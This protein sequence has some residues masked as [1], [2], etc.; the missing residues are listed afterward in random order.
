MLALALSMV[1]CQLG[2]G[3]NGGNNDNNGNNGNNTG[4]TPPAAD[5]NGEDAPIGTEGL[6]YNSQTELRIVLADSA[7]PSELSGELIWAL[8][9][10]LGSRLSVKY[11]D[12]DEAAAH[13]IVIGESG[14]V[15]S[16][17]AYSR[18]EELMDNRGGT[19]F[20]GYVLYSDGSSL[21][22]AYTEELGTQHVEEIIAELAEWATKTSLVKEKGVVSS[23]VYNMYEIY[24]NEDMERRDAA[25]AAL[26]SK[27]GT[28]VVKALKELYSS[29]YTSD[30]I[31]W[32]ANLYEPR[33]CICDNYV[34]GVRVCLHPTD[35]DGNYLCK[36][37]GFYYS[38]SAR[39]TYSF[40]PDI[41]ST[42]QALVFLE[43]TGMLDGFGGNFG[44][45]I[46]GQLRADIVAFTKGLQNPDGYFYHPQWTIEQTQKNWSRVSRDL[47]WS[48]AI[49][50]KFGESPY[51]TTPTGSMTGTGRP[52][53]PA[54]Y[55]TG[56]LAENAASAVSLVTPTASALPAHLQSADAF[57]AYLSQFKMDVY[58]LGYYASNELAA[59]VNQLTAA[60]KQ[61][62]G[63]IKPIL[64][65]FLEE[66]HN[67][68]NGLWRSEVDYDGLNT[69]FKAVMVYSAFGMPFTYAD[70]AVESAI[71]VLSSDEVPGHVCG[72]Y[73]TWYDISG[74]ISNIRKFQGSEI[75]DALQAK[76]IEIAPAAIKNT[77]RYTKIFRKPDGSFSY[78]SDHCS[79]TSQGMTVAL[80]C[81]EGDVNASLICTGGMMDHMGMALGVEL[82]PIFG[83]RQLAEFL[84]IIADNGYSIKDTLPPDVILEFDDESIGIESTTVS[85]A[86]SSG[87]SCAIE[88]DP[89]DEKNK[90]LHFV[91]LAKSGAWDA[92]TV[93]NNTVNINSNCIVFEGKFM[94]AKE[95][96]DQG[97]LVQF[98]IGT[99]GKPSPYFIN[100][101]INGNYVEV[102]EG[103]SDDY[104][105]SF[106]RLLG[107]FPLD[108]WF[109]LR[110][111][112]YF[113]WEDI[114][115]G[116]TPHETVRIKIYT[117]DEL[118]AVSA[119]YMDA[120]MTKFIEGTGTPINETKQALF[121]PM[122]YMRCNAYF[123]DLY[124]GYKNIEYKSEK[125]T[126]GL[127]I[128][129]DADEERKT[130]SFED[131]EQ[132]DITVSGTAAKVNMANG[133]M[134]L[135]STAGTAN[136]KVPALHRTALPNVY[137]LGFD[138]TVDSATA[139]DVFTVTFKEPYRARTIVTYTF[140]CADLDGTTVIAPVYSGTNLL[141]AAAIPVDGTTHHI[142]L[143]LFVDTATTLIYKDG[144]MVASTAQGIIANQFLYEMCDAEISYTGQ[145]SAKID[146]LYCERRVSEF[147][148]EV[149]PKIDRT[150]Y[151]F[152]DG[153]NMGLETGGTVADGVLDLVG[154][155][156]VLVPLNERSA[157]VSAYQFFTAF[158]FGNQTGDQTVYLRYL[159]AEGNMAIGVAITVKSGMMYLYE[160]MNGEKVGEYV[161]SCEY[162]AVGTLRLDLYEAE[163]ALEV[164][165]NDE[166]VLV[167]GVFNGTEYGE[168]SAVKLTAS[169]LVDDIYFDGLTLT[170]T[171]PKL[172]APTRDDTDD[173]ITYDYSSLGNYPIRV[174]SGTN[175]SQNSSIDYVE[176]NGALTKAFIYRKVLEKYVNG[177]SFKFGDDSSR[178]DFVF[179]TDI[180]LE[181]GLAAGG[182]RSSFDFYF[183]NKSG[184]TH[185]Y[186][187]QFNINGGHIWAGLYDGATSEKVDC[188]AIPEDG[189][190]NIRTEVKAG[191]GTKDPNTGTKFTLYIND[192]EIF[193][194]NTFNGSRNSDKIP[195]NEVYQ[196]MLIPLT[197]VRG[198]IY[199]DNTIIK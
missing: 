99:M 93:P 81:D 139:G 70:K 82:P 168:I 5:I 123:D 199:L 80:R 141:S 14:R 68:E 192:V 183:A 103:S 138:I 160:M 151:D 152:A 52:A 18:L 34:D 120:A 190:F 170:Y 194:S 25:F 26:E 10:N 184:G 129:E 165:V 147:D 188:G 196:V 114:M 178:G 36:N 197:N 74:L 49:L 41:E 89:K 3:N 44:G 65:E 135:V 171:N 91:S 110:I 35:K 58:G 130:Y 126:K 167:T 142:E 88:Y 7:F 108:E 174:V 95:G 131:G 125:N 98:Y 29:L 86:S 8:K 22:L 157:Y 83:T 57:K 195:L 94:F 149:K 28:D 166:L 9:D 72:M 105:Y 84:D 119:N 73:N 19:G 162:T 69:V 54:S 101:T 109:K 133:V 55:L 53:S 62:N 106:D 56:R 176:R 16:H 180:K 159:D 50:N 189:W 137:S 154:G 59:Q 2:G 146:N 163:R 42:Y 63:A 175:A 27:L 85:S 116:E 21:A 158:D 97:Y 140:K 71:T 111:E 31:S 122:T 6:I 47:M 67:P 181:G 23:E 38:N 20:G 193:T 134:E 11:D 113:G 128:N 90:V 148:E 48:E 39:N 77:I 186:I 173:V 17:I 4:V 145:M 172:D 15:I 150:V 136:I 66:K 1:A 124:L 33:E 37:G 43:M 177:I 30:I 118:V 187:L 104:R 75:A 107:K 156:S 153:T 32:L 45:F 51:Y 76:A 132:T 144:E 121:F 87:G 12:S 100:F 169:A 117:N 185:M 182:W 92:V 13:E 191:D 115:T 40:L 127:I 78:F 61:L 179:E 96:T 102:W 155:S 24:E 60:N 161:G 79:E 64:F 198:T 143:A 112:Y 46:D 164:Y